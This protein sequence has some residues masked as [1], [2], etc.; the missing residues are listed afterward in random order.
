MNKLVLYDID[1]TLITAGGAG[2]RSLNR[3]FFN[4]FGISEAF[5]TISMAGKTDPQIM[6]E[7]LKLHGIDHLDGNVDRMIEKYLLYLTEEIN[8]PM[9]QIMPGIRESLDLFRSHNMTIGLLTGNL[10]KGA[11]IKLGP[12]G[13][14]DYFTSGAFGSDHEDRDELLPIAIEKYKKQ[15]LK[16]SPGDCYVIGDTP[17]DVQCAKIHDAHCIAVAT[18]PYSVEDLRNTEADIVFES[19]ADVNACY[20]FIVNN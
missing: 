19:L 6:R 12:F 10:E 20:S 2:T 7:G 1:G 3:A 15:G 14:F 16:F 9:R 8:N 5:S 13:I 18:G 17:R 11:E 4:L